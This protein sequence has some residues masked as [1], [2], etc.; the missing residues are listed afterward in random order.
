[1]GPKLK[2]A[3]TEP[4]WFS[5]TVGAKRRSFNYIIYIIQSL[6][7]PYLLGNRMY[8]LSMPYYVLEWSTSIY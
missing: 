8:E 3:S 7:A 2:P 4:S 5:A 1:M 6:Q